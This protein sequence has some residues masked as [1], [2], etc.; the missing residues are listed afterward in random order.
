MKFT[1]RLILGLLALSLNACQGSNLGSSLEGA[2]APATPN[3]EASPSPTAE[4]IPKPSPSVAQTVKP[5]T[6][7]TVNPTINPT[8]TPEAVTLTPAPTSSPSFTPKSSDRLNFQTFKSDRLSN[9]MVAIALQAFPKSTISENSNLLKTFF[10]I[11]FA[12]APIPTAEFSDI[13]QVPASL[14]PWIKEL[15]KLGTISAKTGQ[16]FQPN[17]LVA[18][19]EYARWLLQTN[20][21]FYKNQPSRQIRL[22]QPS[23]TA[24]FPD[25]PN[26]HP[27]FAIIQ[28]LANAG[29][30][31]GTGDRFRPNDPLLREELVQWKIPLDVRQPLPSATWESIS[32]TWGFKDSDRISENALG[33]IFADAQ[34]RDLANIRRSFGFTTLLQ[35]QKPVTRAE[36]AASLWYFGTAVDGISAS[37]VLEQDN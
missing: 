30:I 19:R 22:A 2:I 5:T 28:G 7:P 16:L 34:L 23:D 3:D 8:A 26:N 10:S 18:R 13:E 12:N 21:R 1:F 11:N 36:A 25:I 33:A 4:T 24:S 35:P 31:G 20:N 37:K 29:L 9:Q 15:N 17:T 27:D 14:R 6:N 32:Q